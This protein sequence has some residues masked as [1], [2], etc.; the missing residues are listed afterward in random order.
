MHSIYLN[1]N[2]VSTK[3]SQQGRRKKRFHTRS[4]TC[5]N[6]RFE[7]NPFKSFD[8]IISAQGPHPSM[9]KIQYTF[10]SN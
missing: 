9:D 8:P 2:E 4:F 5:I 6:M 1:S 7:E 10:W 3:K